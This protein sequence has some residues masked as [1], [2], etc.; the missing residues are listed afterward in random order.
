MN[1]TS[2]P[3]IPAIAVELA[4]NAACVLSAALATA[5]TVPITLGRMTIATLS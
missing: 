1:T 3:G 5:L 2:D 4:D